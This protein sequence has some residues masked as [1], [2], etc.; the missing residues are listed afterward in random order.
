MFTIEDENGKFLGT[1]ETRD[2]VKEVLVDY[3]ASLISVFGADRATVGS[4]PVAI[5]P[6]SNVTDDAMEMMGLMR[7]PYLKGDCDGDW[8]FNWF[9]NGHPAGSV[10]FY[11]NPA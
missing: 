7:Q 4:S 8:D 5:M 1:V 9:K 3:T 10:T 11:V 2:R 6:A